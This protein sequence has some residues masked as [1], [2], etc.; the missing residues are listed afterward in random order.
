MVYRKKAVNPLTFR[1][2]VDGLTAVISYNYYFISMLDPVRSVYIQI[3][4]TEE[5]FKNTVK[6]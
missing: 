1:Q 3:Y 4:R 2:N 5:D 6:K